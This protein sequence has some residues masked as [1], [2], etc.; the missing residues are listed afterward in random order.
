MPLQYATI[1]EHLPGVAA[2]PVKE[3]PKR[4]NKVEVAIEEQPQ[5]DKQACVVTPRP[6]SK[7]PNRSAPPVSPVKTD[8][9]L[10]EPQ[11]TGKGGGKG[12]RT[13]VHSFL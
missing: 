7:G 2:G 5:E 10:P 4:V 1:A 8:P 13:A 9:N 11:K 6:K 12:K 3:K